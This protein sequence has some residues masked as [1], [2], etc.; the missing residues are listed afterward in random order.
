MGAAF[1]PG[2]MIKYRVLF[3]K[4]LHIARVVN[5]DGSQILLRTDAEAMS[6]M[7]DGRY[8]VISVNGSTCYSQVVVTEHNIVTV[9]RLWEEKR[10]SQRVDDVI[11]VIYR[12]ADEGSIPKKARLVQGYRSTVTEGEAPDDTV[13][14][15]LRRQLATIE[16]KL[17]LILERLHLHDTGFLNAEHRQ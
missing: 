17:N 9:M 8:I 7:S 2:E 13:N 5:D 1:N 12:I 11:P 15:H 4:T 14:P 6:K 16:S 3:D 10:G